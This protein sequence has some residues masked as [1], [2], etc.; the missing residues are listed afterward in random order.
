[1]LL[2][3]T[4]PIM[5][6]KSRQSKKSGS[7]AISA[8]IRRSTDQVVGFAK[9]RY[10]GKGAARNIAADLNVLR[11]VLN[12]EKKQV[13][14]AITLTTVS[15][16][17]PLISYVVSAAQGTSGSQRDGDSIKVVRVDALLQFA[18]GTG[19]TNLN[20]TNIY[21]VYLVRYLKAPSTS[22]TTPFAIADFLQAD[23]GGGTSI[24][25][26]PNNDLMENFQILH[27]DV[28]RVE[29]PIATSANNVATVV[30]PLSVECGFH[31]TF[32]GAASTTI[33][34]NTLFWVVTALYNNNTGGTG[35]VAINTRLWYVDN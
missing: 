15:N 29:C 11:K 3:F 19:T 8:M 27:S 33:V 6:M 7:S 2:D 28:V 21:T 13:D 24:M 18:F 34:D 10:S 26:L 32:T 22:A 17:A 31:Q 16:V 12:V 1:M 14:T 4:S 9:A 25:S 23:P 20:S 35:Q 30:L 5:S